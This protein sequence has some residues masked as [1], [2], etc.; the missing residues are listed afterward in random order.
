MVQNTLL[1]VLFSIFFCN[2]APAMEEKA[3]IELR[4]EDVRKAYERVSKASVGINYISS[5]T[6]ISIVADEPAPRF[7]IS[8]YWARVIIR[9]HYKGTNSCRV[10]QAMILD[11]VENYERLLA[12]KPNMRKKTLYGMVV[13]QPAKSFYISPRSIKEIVFNYKGRFTHA[14]EKKHL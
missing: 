13:E 6:I 12:L 1:L 5:E 2:F 9:N 10:K 8:P 14:E 7:Y 4:N 11:L 3:L